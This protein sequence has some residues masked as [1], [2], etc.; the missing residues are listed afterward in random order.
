MP[1]L[2]SAA[3]RSDNANSG[4]NM[5]IGWYRI[6]LLMLFCGAIAFELWHF[7]SGSTPTQQSAVPALGKDRPGFALLPADQI[8]LWGEYFAP[9]SHAESWEP[10]LGDMNDVEADLSQIAALSKVDPDPNRRIEHPREYYR[11][12]VAVSINGKRKLF[13]NAICSVDQDANWRKRLAVVRDGGKCFWH[14]MYD[15]STRSFSDLSVNGQA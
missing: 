8:G 5:K 2:H 3:Q 13:L 14:A 7:R 15:Q 11:Q 9:E 12:Y 1:L 6:A 4:E 10:T